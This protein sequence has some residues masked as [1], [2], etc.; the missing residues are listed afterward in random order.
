MFPYNDPQTVL[1]MHRQRVDEMIR[2]AADRRRVRAATAGR[3]RRVGRWPRRDHGGRT[4][5]GVTAAA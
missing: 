1:D 5:T 2:Q 4:N 3:H